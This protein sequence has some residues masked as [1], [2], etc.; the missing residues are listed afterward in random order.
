MHI[1]VETLGAT[2]SPFVLVAGL[3]LIGHV[4][5]GEGL[6]RLVGAWCARAPGGGIGLFALTMCAVAV[7]TAV[8][9]LDT[10][11]V[12]MTPIAINAA[13]AK[14][15]DESAFLYGTIFMSN[16]ASLLLVGSNLTN[17]LVFARRNELG[18]AFARHMVLP[19]IAAVVVTI[20]VVGAWRWRALRDS[21]QSAPAPG[22][23]HTLGLGVL[24]VGFAVVAMLA[25][26]HPAIW[27][28]LVG[29]VVEAVTLARRRGSWR[30]AVTAA[31][32]G[33][34]VTLFVIAVAVG[35]FARWSSL[36]RH[37]LLHA[38]LATTAVAS[39]LSSL[40]IN[41]LPAASLYAAHGVRHPFALLLGLDLGPNCAVTGALS[42]LLWLRIARRHDLRP[43]IVT[44]SAVGTVIAVV[45]ISIGLTLL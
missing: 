15:T 43:S 11:V 42:S 9:N 44:F 17:L 13:R 22:E 27:V 33:T 7:V 31:T 45:A 4:A 35:W 36:T 21:T 38:D 34:L 1:V 23:P 6:F 29:I 24:A 39:A 30:D 28:F 3:L 8:L 32:P 20:V 12:F 18:V 2:W 14:G 19:W 25:I 5:S 37:L 41:N 40:V 26:A 10:S 16:S